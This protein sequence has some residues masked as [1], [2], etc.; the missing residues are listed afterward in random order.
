MKGVRF[1]IQS[2][3]LRV[4]YLGFWVCWDLGVRIMDIEII[5]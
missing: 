5:V 3:E 2:S 1:R 4:Q